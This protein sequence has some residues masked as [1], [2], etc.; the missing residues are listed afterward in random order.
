MYYLLRRFSRKIGTR[1]KVR[2]LRF[3]RFCT[4]EALFQ[5]EEAAA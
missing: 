4:E 3:A 5:T 1:V 2:D